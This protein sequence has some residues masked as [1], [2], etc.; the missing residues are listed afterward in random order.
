[1][2]GMG[3]S[4]NILNFLGTE[5]PLVWYREPSRG[6]ERGKKLRAGRLEQLTEDHPPGILTPPPVSERY[7]CGGT[8]NGG[9]LIADKVSVFVS[10][11]GNN[12]DGAFHRTTS[13]K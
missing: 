13:F 1:M 12:G 11:H 10:A 2:G 4:C 8:E 7:R 3:R 9:D 5:I 6:K